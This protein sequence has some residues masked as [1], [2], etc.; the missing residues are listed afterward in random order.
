M[1]IKRP[2]KNAEETVMVGKTNVVSRP[3]E[4]ADLIS[5]AAGAIAKE[6]KP[7]RASA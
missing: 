6:A 3:K 2:K 1:T 7:G 4:V 5:Q